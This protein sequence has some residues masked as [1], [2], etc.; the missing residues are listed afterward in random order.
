MRA[1]GSDYFENSRRATYVQQRYAID[2]P[3]RFKGYGERAWGITA[4]AGPGRTIRRVDGVEREFFGYCARGAPDGPDDGTL[5]PWAVVSSLPF[6]PEIVLPT[7]RA[8]DIEYPETVHEYGF[9]GSF[10]PT[11]PGD[12]AGRTGWV[13]Q[14]HF[15]LNQGPMVLMTENYRTGIIWD[16]MRDCP[17]IVTGLRRAGF[18]G[19]W[20]RTAGG[21]SR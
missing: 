13:S 9:K 8:L 1:A 6:A 2:N 15:G 14:E 4:S 18:D 21:M 5:S 16:L 11:F 20:L 3:H 7:I 19:G 12:R 17:Y 10:N